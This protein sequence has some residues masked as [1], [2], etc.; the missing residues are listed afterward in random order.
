M[1]LFCE[2]N[3]G[4]IDIDQCIILTVPKKY[5]FL[6]VINPFKRLDILI[7]KS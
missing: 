1:K 6:L 5:M 7:I 2:L 3:I 4:I